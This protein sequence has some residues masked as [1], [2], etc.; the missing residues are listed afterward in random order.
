MIFSK[1]FHRRYHRALLRPQWGPEHRRDIP[2]TVC[3]EFPTGTPMGVCKE[4][5]T[6]TS[7]GVK[8]SSKG[9]EGRGGVKGHLG[10]KN[11]RVE[12]GP[13]DISRVQVCLCRFGRRR[14]IIAL[15]R[16]VGPPP[17]APAPRCVPR[18]GAASS[19]GPGPRR[20][21]L[22]HRADNS[23]PADSLSHPRRHFRRKALVTTATSCVHL[24]ETQFSPTAS[25]RKRNAG[26][27]TQLTL[28]TQQPRK[29]RAE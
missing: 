1:G 27:V 8:G 5:F 13:V 22:R 18:V 16:T 24:K 28:D 15:E 17:P 6:N 3:K 14:S 19:L 26:P 12:V 4:A 11:F 7:E 9:S 2:G 10:E 29:M 21:H 23:G 25:V 20:F